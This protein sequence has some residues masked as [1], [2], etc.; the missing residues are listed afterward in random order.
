MVIATHS[1]TLELQGEHVIRNCHATNT[2][3]SYHMLLK[4]LA[5]YIY[6]YSN[7]E[8]HTTYSYNNAYSIPCDI[9]CIDPAL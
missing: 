5:P 6:I 4:Q 2:E 3:W 7:Y 1:V 9:G 8:Q